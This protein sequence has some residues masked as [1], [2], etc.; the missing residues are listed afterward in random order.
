MKDRADQLMTG[1]H[2]KGIGIS[3]FLFGSV[4]FKGIALGWPGQSDRF[5]T[6]RQLETTRIATVQIF[7]KAVSA[8]QS[9][10]TNLS[11]LQQPG[12]R[13][14]AIYLPACWQPGRAGV[15]RE[16]QVWL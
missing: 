9:H 11:H 2:V 1:D 4:V 5:D 16:E 6:K 14:V 15:G 12:A 13:P 3:V 8:H 7:T 10:G